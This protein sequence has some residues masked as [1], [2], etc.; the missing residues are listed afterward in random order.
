MINNMKKRLFLFAASVVLMLQVQAQSVVEQFRTDPDKSG[1]VYY[2]YPGPSGNSLTAPPKGYKPFYISHYGRHGS[3]YMLSDSDYTKLLNILQSADSANALTPL[4]K[5]KL[6]QMKD[7]WAEANGHTDELAPLGKRQHR[8]IAERMFKNYPQVFKK[9]AN[10][11]AR[12]ILSYAPGKTALRNCF[13]SATSPFT[14]ASQSFIPVNLVCRASIMRL[15]KY[16]YTLA[17]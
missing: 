6:A 7:I 12:S 8:G 3:R 13:P 5:E 15:L 2:A 1:G 14:R 4:G 10:L 16:T 11:S 17:L 9:N